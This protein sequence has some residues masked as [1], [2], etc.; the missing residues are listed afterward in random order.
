MCEYLDKHK[1]LA[2]EDWIS[3]RNIDQK[4]KAPEIMFMANE[5][6]DLD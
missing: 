3:S 4:E 2:P 1:N 6:E 5:E